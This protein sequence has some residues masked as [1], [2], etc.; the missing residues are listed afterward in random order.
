MDHVSTQLP[1]AIAAAAASVV[2]YF[3]AGVTESALIGLGSMLVALTI[4]AFGLNKFWGIR[5]GAA[6]GKA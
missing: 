1:Y 6:R 5:V 4:F 3:F 2:G